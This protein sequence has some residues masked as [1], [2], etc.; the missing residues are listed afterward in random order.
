MSKY[1][2]M[3]QDLKTVSTVCSFIGQDLIQIELASDSKEIS[4]SERRSL[5][6]KIRNERIPLDCSNDE[7]SRRYATTACDLL[8]SE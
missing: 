7:I 5:I 1:I 6:E 2:S 4:Q 8:L 3:L